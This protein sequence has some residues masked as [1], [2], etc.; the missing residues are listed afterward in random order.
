MRFSER[1]GHKPVREA[2]QIESMDEPLRNGLWNRLTL[3][4]W[5][6]IK[7]NPYTDTYY[8]SDRSNHNVKLLCDRIWLLHFKLPIDEL[9]DNW[10]T[11]RGQLKDHFFQCDWSEVYD[12]IE[13]VAQHDERAQFKESFMS[14][15]NLLLEKE[16]SAYRFVDGKIST[17]T[18]QQELEA[19]ESA[20]EGEPDPVKTHLR[21]SLEKMSDREA[22]DYRNSIKESISALEALVRRILSDDKGTLGDLLNKLDDD[23]IE[24][25]PALKKAFSN[26]YG[27]TA[28]E[29]GIRHAL[30]ESDNVDFNDAK[31]M[32][33]VC[34]AFVNFVEGK[35]AREG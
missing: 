8:L 18:D 4:C 20:I 12:F 9:S 16:M 27:Y 30:M 28:D 14:A 6:R 1:Y 35:T 33:V 10:K 22:P 2:I 19:I 26:L 11:V 3:H 23:H 13:F 7:V 32:L 25:H 34:S 5:N 21:A 24:L 17:I 31:F 29:S 15:C